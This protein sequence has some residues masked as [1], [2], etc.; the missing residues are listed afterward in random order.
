MQLSLYEAS[1]MESCIKSDAALLDR[2]AHI[3]TT[4]RL[5]LSDHLL[6]YVTIT[7]NEFM[8]D[9]GLIDES[10]PELTEQ[11]HLLDTT[12]RSLWSMYRPGDTNSVPAALLRSNIYTL[13]DI[14][15]VG[16]EGI[17]DVRGLGKK[18]VEKLEVI[19]AEHADFITWQ[20][21]PTPSDLAEF[22]SRAGQISGMALWPY[23]NFKYNE[24]PSLI[25]VLKMGHEDRLD[26]VRTFGLHNYIPLSVKDAVFNAP[27]VLAIRYEQARFEA[28]Y[29]DS[30]LQHISAGEEAADPSEVPDPKP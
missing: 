25:D 23:F 28:N 14:L 5:A 21:A 7:E 19:A 17:R 22:N 30:W 6:E 11:D 9:I 24:A 13:R 29:D 10:P 4:G 1:L 18:A 16:K 2:G 8:S 26:R 12:V 20:D 27:E 3:T 15:V